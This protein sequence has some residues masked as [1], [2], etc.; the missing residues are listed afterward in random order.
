HLR[1]ALALTLQKAK[2]FC[3]KVTIALLP[4]GIRT[5]LEK[6]EQSQQTIHDRSVSQT[7][8]SDSS[9]QADLECVKREFKA[10]IRNFRSHLAGGDPL[11]SESKEVISDAINLGYKVREVLRGI[12]AC[13]SLDALVQLLDLEAPGVARKGLFTALD[14]IISEMDHDLPLSEGSREIIAEATEKDG[15]VTGQITGPDSDIPW[16]VRLNKKKALEALKSSF[17]DYLVQMTSD[18]ENHPM[19]VSEDSDLSSVT[20]SL[21]RTA[22]MPNLD[23]LSDDLAEA[24]LRSARS[25]LSSGIG[26]DDVGELDY[27]FEP[28][29]A[30]ESSTTEADWDEKFI[31]DWKLRELRKDVEACHNYD[32]L[33]ALVKEK[34][35]EHY[36]YALLSGLRDDYE[37]YGPYLN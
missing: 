5:N 31:G 10:C 12:D 32:D 25:S 36:R 20:G 7:S 19:A 37:K 28:P 8:I 13:D 22:S 27:V 26:S 18:A 35:P 11:R 4:K 3:R 29:V 33:I 23:D 16:A 24:Q 30:E 2:A 6:A 21:S 14:E 17:L 9:V 15:P 34:A 1:M